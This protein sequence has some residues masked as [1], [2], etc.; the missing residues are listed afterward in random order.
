MSRRE[1]D[2]GEIL[3]GLEQVRRESD[4]ARRNGLAWWWLT[5]AFGIAEWGPVVDFAVEHDLARPCVTS[6][7]KRREPLSPVVWTNPIDGSEMIWI[8]PGPFFFGPENE[9]AEC[10]GFSLGRYPVTNAQFDRFLD[11]T[12]YEP[13]A[14]HPDPD[15]FLRHWNG[16]PWKGPKVP[17]GLEQHPVV[18]VSFVDALAY[19]DWAGVTL[20]TEGAWE[21]AARGSD[22][23]MYSWGESLPCQGAWP[24]QKSTGLTNV[25]STETCPVGQYA[26]TRSPYGCED[27][28]GNVSE[29]CQPSGMETKDGHVPQR[30]PELKATKSQPP[31]VPV[32]GSCFLRVGAARMRAAHSRR[33]SAYRRNHWT[34]FRVACFLPCM[35]VA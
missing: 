34:G 21:K 2:I 8:P 24:N 14:D 5:R 19:C 32:R 6:Q 26:R 12:G 3:A 1:Y 23:R 31:Y 27:L 35:A 25:C 7:T 10:A 20:P 13:D 4:P 30:W 33:L 22:G 28:I 15:T 9:H 11:E 17:K 29:W 16:R 18:W